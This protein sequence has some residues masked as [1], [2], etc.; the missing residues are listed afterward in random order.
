MNTTGWIRWV[1][2]AILLTA[3]WQ[4]G[5]VPAVAQ[6]PPAGKLVTAP[7]ALL[8]RSG[9]AWR[10]A[11]P[12]SSLAADTLLLALPEAEIDALNGNLRLH[13]MADLSRRLPEPIFESAVILHP[14]KN[15]DLDFTLERGLVLLQHRRSRGETTARV[16]FG[17]HVWDIVMEK[18]GT[19]LAVVVLGRHAPG[20]R[21]AFHDPGKPF[22][23]EEPTL[24]AY[25][26]V[27]SGGI[28][29]TSN[30]VCFALDAPPG[31]AL[32]HWSSVDG[33]DL[34]PRRLEQLPAFAQPLTAEERQLA[35]AVAQRARKLN[36]APPAKVA[37]ECLE[38]A[39]PRFRL[40]GVT[41][42]GAVDDL[43]GLLAALEHPRH[44]EVREQAVIVLRHWLGRKPGQDAL[45]YHHLT[46][47]R[48]LTPAQAAGVLQLLYGFSDH[49]AES[50][51]LYSS[52]IAY[53]N[54][55][56][57]MIRELVRF[58]LYRLV[59]A[60]S[61]IPFDAADPPEKRAEAVKR[62][63][64]LIPPGELPPRPEAKQKDRP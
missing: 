21:P 46:S 4:A 32:F 25:L 9:E 33:D 12:G 37:A 7:G 50:P 58:H 53:L 19:R 55:D 31:P 47:K 24:F 36:E 5:I 39:N 14:P 16:R 8:Q 38:D 49:D 44:P 48:H 20:I 61:D 15:V 28:E 34:T 30:G 63:K 3:T 1:A 35:E 17:S 11:K 60:G 57:L 56:A 26:L 29:L 23:P 52:L 62:W 27:L 43:E 2:G 42:L 45:L 22:Q 10:P 40:M 54:H 59:P 6:G 51:E 13:L 18:P 64:A 41:L